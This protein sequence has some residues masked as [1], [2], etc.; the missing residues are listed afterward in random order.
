[1]QE[2]KT[3]E[4]PVIA[5]VVVTEPLAPSQANTSEVVTDV[6][7]IV[8]QAARKYGIDEEHFVQIAKCE[9]TLNP[10]AVNYNYSE[11]GKDFPSGLFQHLNNYWSSRA[12]K[13]GYHGS[14][15]FN[16][17]ANANVTAQMFRDGASNLWECN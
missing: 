9:S 4:V 8:L 11:N 3:E 15:V 13:Y 17:E 16:A 2:V 7:A 1:V 10:Q 6:E 5:E 14:S 12:T